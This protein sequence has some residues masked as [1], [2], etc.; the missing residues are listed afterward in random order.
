VH[1]AL[2]AG[3]RGAVWVAGDEDEREP[4]AG[5]MKVARLGEVPAALAALAPPSAPAPG[6]RRS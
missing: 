6:A 4:P 2:A 3:M 5:A 1:G